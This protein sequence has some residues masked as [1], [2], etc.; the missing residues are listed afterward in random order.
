M[1]EFIL[2][3]NVTKEML[4]ER[5]FEI[6]QN[7]AYAILRNEETKDK[8]II[9]PLDSASK[10]NRRANWRFTSVADSLN[11][12]LVDY[13]DL[14]K[15]EYTEDDMETKEISRWIK[16][17]HENAKEHGWWDTEKS[18]PEV[19]ALIHSE[20]SES[21]EEYRD[22]KENLYFDE[23][24]KPEGVAVELA[25][26]VIRIMDYCGKEGIDLEEIIAIK[27][28]YNKKRAYRHGGKKV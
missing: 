20:V 25:D 15:N 6:S 17:I 8:D 16:D 12:Y 1:R 2:K 9:I 26:A 7:Q 24:G 23:N 3:D 21:L 4:I 18:F 19:I 27:H 28:K 5:G 10:N 11:P 22:G 13:L 14:F